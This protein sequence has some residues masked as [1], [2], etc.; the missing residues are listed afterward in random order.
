MTGSGDRPGEGS[1]DEDVADAVFRLMRRE[2]PGFS[3]DDMNCEFFDLGLNSLGLL[4]VRMAIERETGI[5]ISD[6]TWSDVERPADLARLMASQSRT[7][8]G[9]VVRREPDSPAVV[10]VAASARG[11]PAPSPLAEGPFGW[12]PD[13]VRSDPELENA[14][15]TSGVDVTWDRLIGLS[16]HNID[17]NQT[18]RID[19]WLANWVDSG[20]PG[21]RAATKVRLAVL[22]SSTCSHL[23]APIRV[24]GLRRG[25]EITTYEADFG[26]YFQELSDPNSPLQTFQPDIVLL[27]LDA[28]H[29]TRGV[30]AAADQATTEQLLDDTVGHIRQCWALAQR[31]N[32]A[33]IHQTALPL[34]SPVLGS[35]EHRLYGS[36]QR[37]VSALNDRLRNVADL[38][39]VD[40]LAIDDFA[41]S[42][43]IRSLHDPM[44]WHRAKM[45]VTPSAAPLY[46]ELVARL[47]AAKTGR[48]SKC[49]VL[50]L[51]N[52]LW[53]GVIGDDGVDG[54]LLGQGNSI[55]EAFVEFQR[56][57]IDLAKRGVILAVCSKNDEAN[58]LQPFLTHPDMILR[59]S[60]ISC[61]VANWQ[62]K[63]SNIR[64]IAAE[65]D[66][67][68]DSIVFVD[69]NPFERG[70][71]RK[72]L[73]MVSVPEMPSDP[74]LFSRVLSDAGYFE[75]GRVT[76][77]DRART[78]HYDVKARQA[79]SQ[80][81]AS[82]LPAYLESL[83][84]TLAWSRFD[85]AG[86]HRIVQLVNKTNQF[87]LTTRRYTE[88]N[89]RSLMADPDAFG[90]QFRLTDCY[91]DNG[92]IGIVVG[93]KAGADFVIEN[94]LMSCRVLGREVERAM[95]S[96]VA[97]VAGANDA[98]TL[99][100]EY[101]PTPRNGMVSDLFEKMGFENIERSDSGATRWKRRLDQPLDQ[102]PFIRIEQVG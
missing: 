97:A 59:R 74:A 25:I 51:D 47:L 12:L 36:R 28:F 3:A 62:D 38:D 58:A 71:V 89:V 48:A 67:G 10:H 63:A 22:G 53:G 5:L 64:H 13:P 41:M 4:N 102:S 55:G 82:D 32:S 40:L 95:L 68:L 73:L 26:Q 49:L 45:E 17:F 87:N 81:M 100:G 43:G 85:A 75:G 37:F 18:N 9:P 30:D 57:V 52:T 27:A 94:W 1:P 20:R 14:D 93:R 96:V 99:I 39:G 44:T 101:I 66:I 24:G 98:Q 91:A 23:L 60:D 33:V 29:L 69:D 50:D 6:R 7:P 72:E 83:D 86:L 16:N 54:I 92:V 2:C 84:M 70:L 35:N 8:A 46:G 11:V 31:M 76:D 21:G 19:R 15:F 56:Y 88:M 80:V 78:R 65:L 42:Q 77:E 61:F 79:A 34:F 90:I